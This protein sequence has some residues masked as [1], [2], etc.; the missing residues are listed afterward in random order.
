MGK[1]IFHTGTPLGIVIGHTACVAFFLAV[2]CLYIMQSS[3]RSLKRKLHFCAVDC[4]HEYL[5]QWHIT[6]AAWRRCSSRLVLP[7]WPMVHAFIR[8]TLEPVI[9]ACHA[10]GV[11]VEH[12]GKLSSPFSCAPGH[13]AYVSIVLAESSLCDTFHLRSPTCYILRMLFVMSKVAIM[14]IIIKHF[15]WT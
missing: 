2:I 1:I 14:R 11:A 4:M 6:L 7:C 10:W 15:T 5:F 13:N 12:V 3:V 8:T 9:L